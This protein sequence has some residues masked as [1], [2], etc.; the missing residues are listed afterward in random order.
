MTIWIC[1]NISGYVKL[2]SVASDP[3]CEEYYCRD[4]NRSITK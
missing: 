3:D 4:P 1:D 2:T